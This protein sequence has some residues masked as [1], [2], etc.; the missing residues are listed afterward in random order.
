MSHNCHTAPK[1]C[2][3]LFRNGQ[4]VSGEI[5]GDSLSRNKEFIITFPNAESVNVAASLHPELGYRFQWSC[6][7][8]PHEAFIGTISDLILKYFAV[9]GEELGTES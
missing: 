1:V 4:S 9:T 8:H 2:F 3:L 5:A 6:P 7:G